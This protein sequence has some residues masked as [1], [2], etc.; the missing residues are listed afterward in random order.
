MKKILKR[1]VATLACVA[2]AFSL[3]LPLAQGAGENSAPIAASA[4]ASSDYVRPALS[5]DNFAFENGAMTNTTK[6]GEAAISNPLTKLGFKLN[7]KNPELLDFINNEN[8]SAYFIFTLYRDNGGEAQAKYRVLC[9]IS[10]YTV[11]WG[12]QLVEYDEAISSFEYLDFTTAQVIGHTIVDYAESGESVTITDETWGTFIIDQVCFTEKHTPLYY[13]DEDNIKKLGIY[14]MLDSLNVGYFL[15]LDYK[16][17]DYVKT[18]TKWK[19]TSLFKLWEPVKVKVYNEI[20]GSIATPTRSI[21][22]VIYNINAAGMMEKEFTNADELA[23]AQEILAGKEE[24]IKV[25]YLERIGETPFATKKSA[26]ITIPMIG[27]VPR[28]GDVEEALG[29]SLIVL[30]S[31]TSP[32]GAFVYNETTGIWT[33]QYS[34]NV[35]LETR[36]VDGNSHNQYLD[37]NQSF[38]DSFYYLR[39][40]VSSELYEY[41]WSQTVKDYPILNS[42]EPETVYGY[43]GQA[44]IPNMDGVSANEL[45]AQLF[46]TKTEF[47]NILNYQSRY[48]LLTMEHYN[49]LLEAYNYSWIDAFWKTLLKPVG[50]LSFSTHGADY[51]I[52]YAAVEPRASISN[53]GSTEIGNGNGV[54]ENELRQMSEKIWEKA[55]ESI[56][57]ANERADKMITM[58]MVFT[59]A[60]MMMALGFGAV[61]VYRMLPAKNSSRTKKNKKK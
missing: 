1:L 8:D 2:L 39:T 54:F 24:T 57:D 48:T 59:G 19:R 40:E 3:L 52:Y 55:Q 21:Y 23:L 44:W 10:G 50:D 58:L 14:T 29:K 22:N 32:N 30:D 6:T 16:F 26:T 28:K 56:D 60:A 18:V 7:L 49:A 27:G 34:K 17:N 20:E 53:S 43:F 46:N 5:D 45:F 12:H 9:A 35:W 4:E 36:T 61:R 38:A 11:F 37:I 33:T 42:Y 15:Q 25:E 31:P 51:Y 41:F 13:Y 47:Y